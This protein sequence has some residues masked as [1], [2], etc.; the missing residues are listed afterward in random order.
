MKTFTFVVYTVFSALALAASQSATITCGANADARSLCNTETALTEAL[1]RNDA[2]S[3][4]QIY[5]DEF[6]LINYRGRRI[7][8][9][10]G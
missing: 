10:L 3:L 8:P 9:M 7:T 6:Q 4:S 2:D 1:R 5:A